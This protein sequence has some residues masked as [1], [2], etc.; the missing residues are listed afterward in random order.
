MLSIKRE[1]EVVD[2]KQKG[3]QTRFVQDI[4]IGRNM[5]RGYFANW[6]I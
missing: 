4:P 1:N 5:I 6:K 3:V 2:I